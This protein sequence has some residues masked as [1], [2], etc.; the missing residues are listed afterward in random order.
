MPAAQKDPQ[1]DAVDNVICKEGCL[2][3]GFGR[4]AE[5]IGEAHELDE[6]DGNCESRQ[7]QL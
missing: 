1:S 6:S 3:N 5:S 2:R 7:A 4:I